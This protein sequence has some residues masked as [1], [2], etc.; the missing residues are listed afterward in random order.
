MNAPHLHPRPVLHSA[1]AISVPDAQAEALDRRRVLQTHLRAYKESGHDPMRSGAALG[2]FGALRLVGS[3]RGR[4]R[5]W[6]R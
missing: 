6:D 1:Y 4:P 3:M 2:P 5:H